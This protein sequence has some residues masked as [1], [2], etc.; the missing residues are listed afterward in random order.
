MGLSQFFLLVPLTIFATLLAGIWYVVEPGRARADD[1]NPV[2]PQPT[3]RAPGLPGRDRLDHLV[4]SSRA[5]APGAEG[6]RSPV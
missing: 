1:R 4:V 6:E 2:G 5:F 3:S